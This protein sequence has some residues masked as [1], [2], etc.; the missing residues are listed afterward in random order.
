M[1]YP[2]DRIRA[3]IPALSREMNDQPVVYFDGPSGSQVA[4][5][6]IDAMVEYMT[7]GSANLGGAY[8]T[9]Q[10]SDQIVEDAR[11]AMADMLGGKPSEIAFGQNMTSLTFDLSRA[12]ARTWDLDGN[13]VVTEID[14]R[15]NVDPWIIAAEEKGIEVRWIP[16]DTE[17]LTLDYKD[18]NTIIDEDT[19][20][21]A[22]THASNGIG[23]ITDLKPVVERSKEVDAI[24]VMDAVHSA[25][26]VSIDRDELGVDI[27]LCSAYKFFGPHTG[28][29]SIRE[30]IFDPL[31]TYRL[32]TAPVNSPGKMETGTQSIES[33]AGVIGA[34]NFIAEQGAG[35]TRK[36]QIKSAFAKIHEHEDALADYIRTELGA[37]DTITLYQSEGPKTP[38][39]AFRHNA[40]TPH[41]LVKKLGDQGIFLGNGHFYART[42]G[43]ILELNDK[44][45]WNRI[46][47]APYS[48]RHEA[49][50]FVQAIKNL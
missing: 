5:Q 13:I 38:T 16:L 39:I 11:E 34:V 22:I 1:S 44:G 49:E 7:M 48:T 4:E 41:D 50:R 33:L 42:I 32:T 14:H 20:L 30:G 27:V 46:G 21:V 29:V 43:D 47:M 8:P 12:L 3:Q 25:P 9:S 18:L 19:Q 26:H 45:G 15:A 6:S 10:E 28:I 36:E 2:V 31:Q 35:E 37:L 24:L 17:T 23:T 40:V